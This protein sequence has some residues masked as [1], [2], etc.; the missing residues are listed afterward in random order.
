[1]QKKVIVIAFIVV[2]LIWVG[3]MVSRHLGQSQERAKRHQTEYGKRI[4]IAKKSPNAGLVQI[5]MRLNKYKAEKGVYPERLM[6]LYPEYLPSE[7]F[8]REVP[9]DYERTGE[10]NFS[11]KKTITLGGGERTTFI[12]KG[13]RVESVSSTAVAAVE[14]ED[15][16]G[17]ASE[18]ELG[19]MVASPVLTSEAED[20]DETES[21]ETTKED[22]FGPMI[23]TA[24]EIVTVIKEEIAPGIDP[25]IGSAY[26][27]WKDEKGRLGFGNVDYPSSYRLS[28]YSNGMYQ[29]IKRTERSEQ[30]SDFARRMNQEKSKDEIASCISKQTLV[31]KNKDG[32]LGFGNVDYPKG[33]DVSHINVNGVWQEKRKVQP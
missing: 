3:Y 6:D 12:D 19:V 18:E 4:E 30:G 33:E 17:F 31:W 32:T 26:L 1:M 20:T 16:F 29:N 8:I 28:V 21:A 14:E 23:A 10:N 15:D 22:S 25:R 13:L 7:A 2:V 5:G 9:W 24:P 11:L 27:V